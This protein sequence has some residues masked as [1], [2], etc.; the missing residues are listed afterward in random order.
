MVYPYEGIL[1]GIMNEE[2]PIHATKRVN[3]DKIILST[4]NQSQM[5]T[6]CIIPFKWNIHNREIKRQKVSI[7]QCLPRT[8]GRETWGEMKSDC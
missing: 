5:T 4:R 6:Y 8:S 1:L 2:V 3:S 7:D